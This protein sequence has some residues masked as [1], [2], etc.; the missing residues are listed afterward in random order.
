[1]FSFVSLYAQNVEGE[2]IIFFNEL[3]NIIEEHAIS[4]D[5]LIIGGDFNCCLD[6]SECKIKTHIN[7]VKAETF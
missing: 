2:R 1:M 6:T 7:D 3:N 4:K 5:T